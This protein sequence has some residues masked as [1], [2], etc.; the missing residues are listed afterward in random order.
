MILHTSLPLT[1]MLNTGGGSYGFNP[2]LYDTGFVCLSVI[3]TWSASS[4][5][6]NETTI[7]H[8]LRVLQACVLVEEPFCN[9]PSYQGHK[10]SSMSLN[11]NRK[12][13]EKTVK[14]AMLDWLERK[15]YRLAHLGSY[16]RPVLLG[17]RSKPEG[18]KD[19]IWDEVVKRHFAANK[20]QILDTIKQWIADRAPESKKKEKK[21]KVDMT[22]DFPAP[23]GHPSKSIHDPMT[24]GTPMGLHDEPILHFSLPA[25]SPH[26]H[27]H[28]GWYQA[29]LDSLPAGNTPHV[30]ML[31]MTPQLTH[32][33]YQTLQYPAGAAP[34]IQNAPAQ[35]DAAGM[36]KKPSQLGQS[37]DSM[38]QH[39]AVASSP[40]QN[41]LVPTGAPGVYTM[42]SKPPQLTASQQQALDDAITPAPPV[43]KTPSPGSI[44]G[45][46]S[47]AQQP[48]LTQQQIQ[49]YVA[50][51]AS[52]DQNALPQGDA[53]GKKKGRMMD[54]SPE[55]EVMVEVVDEK[56]REFVKELKKAVVALGNGER[57]GLTTV[58]ELYEQAEEEDEE[59]HYEAYEDDGAW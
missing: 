47:M 36:Q 48:P 43:Q 52:A 46:L 21:K 35:G 7:I 27:M 14:L 53:A 51:A 23:P 45:V 28:T 24:F 19:G 16:G 59:A 34:P 11:Y 31:S 8:V 30:D 49:Q 4:W 6:P 42:L 37:L 57:L 29:Y 5:V 15:S 17:Q 39:P 56:L 33:Q 10:G 12:M 40:V 41:A 25:Q 32:S 13:H 18:R 22:E 26:A 2:N 9:E 20:E 44:F 50:D 58:T 1:N 55:E 38:L 3:G 54:D